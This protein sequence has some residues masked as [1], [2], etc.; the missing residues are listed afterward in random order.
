MPQA[1]RRPSAS[2]GSPA[3]IPGPREPGCCR[4]CRHRRNALKTRVSRCSH[5]APTL[6]CFFAA[7]RHPVPLPAP[8][9]EPAPVGHPQP[10]PHTR[11][12]AAAA[13]APA[14]PLRC[15]TSAPRRAAPTAPPR[16][17]LRGLRLAAS[18][19]AALP[20][21]AIGPPRLLLCSRHRLQGQIG[22]GRR[23][24][25]AFWVMVFTEVAPPR[26][27]AGPRLQLPACRGVRG[28]YSDWA[29]GAR[30]AV[31][32]VPPVP[33]NCASLGVAAELRRAVRREKR[34]S[35]EALLCCKAARGGQS[36]A[37]PV[38]RH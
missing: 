31:P 25:G 35:G 37:A 3:S 1:T 12:A 27:L 2:G 22:P 17:S 23:R 28:G 8:G 11:G 30:G 36:P 7:R 19:G 6:S 26:G 32:G 33:G 16:L 38:N 24:R 34:C 4:T 5:D 20:W 13:H 10:P 21:P 15:R 29:S 14:W 9:P 18:P